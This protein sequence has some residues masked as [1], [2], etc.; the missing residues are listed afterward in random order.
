MLHAIVWTPAVLASLA[1][2]VYLTGMFLRPSA[3]YSGRHHLKG[4]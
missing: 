2:V 4:F 1:T 3:R